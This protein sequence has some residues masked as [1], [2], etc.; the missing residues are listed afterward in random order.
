VAAPR[1]SQYEIFQ[2][3]G[4]PITDRCLS[5]YN[6]T[7]FAYGQTGSGKTFTMQGPLELN[8]A[9]WEER[10]LIPRILEYLFDKISEIEAEVNIIL[11][12]IILYQSYFA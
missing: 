1:S 7:I 4:K 10:G 2:H 5:G 8:E 12:V 6:G 9:N 11:Q 3:V